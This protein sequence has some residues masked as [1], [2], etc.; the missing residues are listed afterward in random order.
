M[1]T[2]GPPPISSQRRAELS[3]LKQSVVA[4]TVE[5]LLTH[6]PSAGITPITG[7]HSRGMRSAMKLA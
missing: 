4:S 3:V 6:Y 1:F 7:F 2:N 5:I